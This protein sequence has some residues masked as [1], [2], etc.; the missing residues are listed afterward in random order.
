MKHFSPI[1]SL[2]DLKKQYRELALAN[3]PDRG[4]STEAM[5]EINEEFARLYAVWVLRGGE[6]DLADAGAYTARFQNEYRWMGENYRK[7]R[8]YDKAKIFESVRQFLKETYPRYTFSV[9]KES[10]NAYTVSLMKADFYPYKDHAQL[11]G[12]VNHYWIDD[13]E[14]LSE[15][16]KEVMKNVI[17]YVESWNFDDSDIQSDYFH[18]NFYVDFEVGRH[19]KSF[20]YCQNLIGE[21]P[22]EY[23]RKTG[24][25]G[26][27]VR[28]AIGESN[29]FWY[30]QRYDKDL[31]EFVDETDKPKVLCKDDE[32]HYPLW[33]S[34]PSLV[35]A[36]IEKLAAVGI[37]ARATRRGIELVGYSEDLQAALAKEEAEED[38]REAAFHAALAAKQSPAPKE[39]KPAEPAAPDVPSPSAKAPRL[40]IVYY[41]EKAIAVT[42]DTRPLADKLRALGGRFNARLS[43]GPGWI[44]SKRHEQDVRR[45]LGENLSAA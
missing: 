21:K 41:S 42:G 1:T 7:T 38:A 43:C 17:D 11:R 3:H 36:R 15:R 25:V 33:Y 35:K 8:S 45:A 26:K 4:G 13:N 2:S 19:G 5:Q 28:E 30:L 32:N 31:G 18:V 34:Q 20:E 12:H 40:T 6:D 27:K 29:I 10:Y 23:R 37:Q 39:E 44:F 16:G 9:R 24:P 22:K 14:E